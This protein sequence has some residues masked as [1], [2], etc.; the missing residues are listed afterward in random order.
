MRAIFLI[1][2]LLLASVAPAQAQS[3]APEA[4]VSAQQQALARRFVSIGGSEDLF[5]RGAVI[6][7]EATLQQQGFNLSER[8]RLILKQTLET[9]F[10]APAGIYLDEMTDYYA[11]HSSTA[12]LEAALAY[13]ESET[14]GRYVIAAI[15][16]VMT[17]LSFALSDD[18]GA[19]P[20]TA[21]TLDPTH[22]A[23]ANRLG[24]A[25]LQRLSAVEIEQMALYG[26]D[27]GAFT[28]WVGRF[29]AA[30]LSPADLEAAVLWSE[31][32]ASQRLERSSPLRAHAE[33]LAALRAMRAMDTQA[34]GA[35]IDKVLAETPT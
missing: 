4:A 18:F 8:Q 12:D 29:M 20:A 30:C 15:D 32:E 26:L 28:A 34:L 25:F 7:I 21:E 17:I 24:A 3:Q 33:Q 27:S 5:V 22:E 2:L 11:A 13:Y 1:C 9:S 10:T 19:L 16:L 23:L 14:G 35:A 6:G 31:S